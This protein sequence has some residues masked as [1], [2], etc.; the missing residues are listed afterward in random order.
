M[1][2]L[3]PALR[4]RQA[5]ANVARVTTLPQ[6]RYSGHMSGGIIDLEKTYFDTTRIMESAAG[7]TSFAGVILNDE[8]V[9]GMLLRHDNHADVYSVSAM[10][11]QTT[12]LE[13]RAYSLEALPEKV[14]RYRLRNI[15]RLASRTV[16]ETR[17]HGMVVIVY[18]AGGCER[19]EDSGDSVPLGLLPLDEKPGVV[20]AN[21][22]LQQKPSR[23]REKARIRQFERRKSSRQRKRQSRAVEDQAST[24]IAVE[25]VAT[26]EAE[27]E[28]RQTTAIE[29]PAG[30]STNDEKALTKEVDEENPIHT[31]LQHAQSDQPPTRRHLA[32]RCRRAL[33]KI[34]ENDDE[35]EHVLEV[36][37]REVKRLRLE[38]KK[39][40]GLVD[41]RDSSATIKIPEKTYRGWI[42]PTSA[43]A[44][45]EILAGI[46]GGVDYVNMSY[47]DP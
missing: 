35:K 21:K 16:L 34:F 4:P 25:K 8:F 29:C 38:Q 43:Q 11:S 3:F 44:R 6:P 28:I 27:N 17:W 20:V 1:H 13:A 32:A 39:P 18:K 23:Q 40:L 22:K 26:V 30:T 15:K 36:M 7:E 45:N 10:S 14:R 9:L 24:A 47:P 41:R 42:R 19:I 31:L 33:E 5:H 37:Y 46:C 12:L 2:Y